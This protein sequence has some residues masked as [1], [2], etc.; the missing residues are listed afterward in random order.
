MRTPPRPWIF[1]KVRVITTFC[2]RRRPARCRPRSRCGGHIRHRPRRAPAA[3]ASAVPHA[4]GAPLRTA[5]RCRSGCSDWRGRRSWSARV[6]AARIA[7][8]SA[9][10]SVSLTDDRHRAGRLDVDPVDQE[11]VLGEDRLVARRQIGLRQQAEDL[12]GAVRADDVGRVQPMRLGDRLAQPASPS[13]PD[14]TP[15]SPASL[16]HR[17]D[18]LGRGAERVLVGRQLVTLA[19]PAGAAL[20]PG[21]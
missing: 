8:T 21:T 11:A 13:R 15:A 10:S 19:T 20:L 5:D 14:K 7:S 12:V 1:E 17:L 3:R 6:T 4:A 2:D 9:R 16:A 18:R